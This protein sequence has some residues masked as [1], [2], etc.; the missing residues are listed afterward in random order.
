MRARLGVIL[1]L[2]LAAS[3]D[4]AA[5]VASHN[6][7]EIAPGI[8]TFL[9]PTTPRT[10]VDPA[11]KARRAV[12]QD[13]TFSAQEMAYD[14]ENGIVVARGAVEIAR[15][16][17]IINADQV[18][19][20]QQLDLVIAEGNVVMLQP[21]GDVTF[22][23]RAE[24]SDAVK[25]GVI[26][27]FKGRLADNSV[28]VAKRAERENPAV[29]NLYKAKYTPCNLC[30]GVAPFWSLNAN[31]IHVDELEERVEYHGA[32]VEFAGVPAM[33]LPVLSH[34]TPNAQAKSGFLTPQYAVNNNL[35]TIVQVPYYWR[36]SH[37]REAVVSVMHTS[38]EGYL[39]RSNYTQ[40]TD[41]GRHSIDASG[42]FPTSAGNGTGPDALDFRGHIFAKGS[43]NLGEISQVGYDINR[44]TDDTY[45]RRYNFGDERVLFSRLFA[46]AAQGRSFAIAQGLAIQGLRETD[47]SRTTPLVLPMLQGNYETAP[48]A[49]GVRYHFGGDLQALSRQDGIEQRR[50]SI[51]TGASLPYVTDNGQII[52]TTLNLR[53]DFYQTDNIVTANGQDNATSLRTLPQLG[54]EWRYPLLRQFD[55]DSMTLEPIVLA[56]VQR[57][58]GV[59][60]TISNEDS[61]LLELT[62][63]N[64]FSLDRSTGLDLF[65]SGTRIAYGAR[66]QYLMKNGG[67]IDGLI[68]QN[69]S[70]STDAPFPNSTTPGS[71]FSDYIGRVAY[72]LTPISLSYRFAFD[73]EDLKLNRNEFQANYASPW[74]ALGVGYHSLTNNRFVA[75]S[76]ERTLDIAVPITDHW[77]IH[78]GNRRDLELDRDVVNSA[79]IV[80]R[81]E[82]FNIHFTAM[83]TFT[84]DRDVP[85]ITQY[86]FQ[87]SLKNLGTVGGL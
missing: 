7:P 28:F 35:G 14:R 72:R 21:S 30:E 12:D 55:T 6:N 62:D 20:F 41:G 58:G 42:T 68:G 24:L 31:E 82:C 3:G 78:A 15:Q 46:E 23:E 49:L 52:T 73:N 67:S 47:N 50:I 69:Y 40:L 54:L 56:V 66:S 44:T 63:T 48:D 37:D 33:Y 25:S 29:T 60:A 53:Q 75:N 26:Q 85:Q 34:P 84:S 81:N 11:T 71:H 45:L 1:L 36:I 65:D 19:Y 5:Q 70:F 27:A 59:P 22:A 80:Y 8:T 18:T 74:L 39:F 87:F 4:A 38:S 86:L 9:G 13:V 57:D 83:R 43:E 79:G 17:T 77:V 16:D 61:R 10:P 32:T 2:W 76:K 64:L 51:N